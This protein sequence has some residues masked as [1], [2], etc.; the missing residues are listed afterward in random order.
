MKIAG[1]QFKTTLIRGWSNKTDSSKYDAD[2][3]EEKG[4]Q[5]QEIQATRLAEM[6]A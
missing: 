1:I 5:K 6:L 3:D 2:N 4:I